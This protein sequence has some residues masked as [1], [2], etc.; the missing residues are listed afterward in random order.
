MEFD[1]AFKEFDYSLRANM[2]FR[3]ESCVKALM[4]EL[5]VEELRA[6]L[7]YQMMQM[8][9]LQ[10]GVMVNQVIMDGSL[11]AYSELDFL[12][13]KKPFTVAHSL[14]NLPYIISKTGEGNMGDMLTRERS[15]FK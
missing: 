14:L 13:R 1:L 4:T 3:S 7:H 15:K 10:V 5:G 2:D 8:Q 6:V 12:A 9:L 11:K